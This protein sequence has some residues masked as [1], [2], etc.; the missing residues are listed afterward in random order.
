MLKQIG[1]VAF[2]LV[3]VATSSSAF[4]QQVQRTRGIAVQAAPAPAATRA[5]AIEPNVAAAPAEQPTEFSAQV[6]TEAPVVAEVTAVD[7]PAVVAPP[8][9]EKAPVV[10]KEKVLVKVK[11]I[12][13]FAGYGHGGYGY[14]SRYAGGYAEKCH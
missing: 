12:E 3:V 10:V 13:R 4:A 7:A 11:P 6:T 1:I 2:G 9:V 14:S 5:I 8:V